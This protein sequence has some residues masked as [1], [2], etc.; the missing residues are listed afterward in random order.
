MKRIQDG[1]SKTNSLD[2]KSELQA[3]NERRVEAL[4]EIN[5]KYVRTE[6]HM[7]QHSD[8]SRIDQIKHSLKVQEEREAQM[9]N[10]KN[11]I[12][13]RQHEEVDDRQ[14]TKRNLEFT[15]HYL[16]HHSAHMDEGTRN[17]TLE[18]Q[19]HR[20]EQLENLD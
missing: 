11:I 14:N 16:Q 17:K 15:D 18:K 4:L 10:L 3:A 7:E 9:E 1:E 6:R 20:K 5:D 13:N 12:V 8:I 19:E 2:S